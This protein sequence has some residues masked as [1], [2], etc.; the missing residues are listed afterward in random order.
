MNILFLLRL[1]PVYGGGETV[2]ICLANEMVKRGWNVSVVYFKDSVR[3]TL[4]FID[5][6]IDAIKIDGIDCDEFYSSMSD[7]SDAAKRLADIVKCKDIDVVINQWWPV[8]FIKDLKHDVPS[9]KVVKCFHTALF[10]PTSSTGVKGMLKTV[11][12][13]MYNALKKKK[14]LKQVDEFLPFVDK[15]VFLSPKFQQQYEMWSKKSEEWK[16]KLDAV[17]NPLVFSSDISE[18]EIAQKENRV[19][20]VGRMVESCKKF[21]TA[22]KAW[23]KIEQDKSLEDW[24]IH[25]LGEGPDLDSYKVLAKELGLKRVHFEGFQNPLPF[26]KQAKVFLMTSAFEGFPMVLVEAQQCGVVPVA[27]DSYLSL[28]DIIKDGKNGFIVPNNDIDAFVKKVIILMKN[29][30]LLAELRMGGLKSCQQF[31]VKKIVDRWEELFNGLL[32]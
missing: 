30:D 14:A 8:E 18:K 7:A 20:L 31:S 29:E 16:G 12:K 25:F 15:Y 26:Y 6:K 28:H 3:A 11:F 21:S 4:P 1:W 5:Q 10:T 24:S 17:P 9:V 13:P 32:N 22:L 19:L 23:Q 2:T 27:V